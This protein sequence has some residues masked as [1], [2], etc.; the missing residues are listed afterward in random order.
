MRLL[1]LRFERSNG[2]NVLCAGIKNCDPKVSPHDV[3]LYN[4]A[5][6]W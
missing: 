5:N 3:H 6:H 2:L 1:L 4:G